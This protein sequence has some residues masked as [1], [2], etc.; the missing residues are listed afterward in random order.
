MRQ[1]YLYF[2]ALIFFISCGDRKINEQSVSIT[3]NNNLPTYEE[4]NKEGLNEEIKSPSIREYGQNIID[5]EIQPSDNNETIACLDSISDN[6]LKT[7]LFFF[8]VYRVIAKKSDGA[9]GEIIGSYTKGYFGSYPIEALQNFKHL[10]EPERK[11]FIDNLAFE[12]YASGTDYDT[13]IDDYISSIYSSCEE[14]KVE[15]E[16]LEDMRRDL[17]AKVSEINY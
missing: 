16:I 17:K 12:F 11:L 8:Q 1:L 10:P 13:D 4:S 14:C 5:N 9:L 3:A 15:K 6:D 2:I 7:R